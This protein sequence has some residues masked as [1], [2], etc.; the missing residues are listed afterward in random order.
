MKTG[1][2]SALAAALSLGLV[3][4]TE[5]E[6]WT[7]AH[8]TFG[9]G[10]T[11]I[12]F[13]SASGSGPSDAGRADDWSPFIAGGYDWAYGN[14][15]L[16]VVADLDGANVPDDFL[17]GGKGFTGESDWFATLRARVGMPVSERMHVYASGGLALMGVSSNSVAFFGTVTDHKTLT[18]AAV[19]L[20]MEYMLSPGRHLSVEYLHADFGETAFHDGAMTREPALDT[21]RLGYTL[22]F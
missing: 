18:G 16:G 19:G 5:A 6:D 10:N 11:A 17:S 22:R 1:M 14:L 15:T 8:L 4:A 13:R 2:I 21:V 3:S 9:I 7:G 12:D 20:G